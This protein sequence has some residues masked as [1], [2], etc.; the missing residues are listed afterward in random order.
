M[1]DVDLHVDSVFA[2]TSCRSTLVD[3]HVRGRKHRCSGVHSYNYDCSSSQQHP[4]YPCDL[5]YMYSC[6]VAF[7]SLYFGMSIL[8]PGNAPQKSIFDTLI[9]EANFASM[10]H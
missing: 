1:H 9:H 6:R 10:R 7:C 4:R 5:Q 2:V 3:L 8:C